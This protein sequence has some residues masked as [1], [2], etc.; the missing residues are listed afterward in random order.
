GTAV[1]KNFVSIAGPQGGN[2]FDALTTPDSPTQ[3]Y[4]RFD[5]IPFTTATNP[6]I[7]Q[8]KVFYH[9]YAGK[10]FPAYYQVYLR[11][12]GGSFYQDASFR[13]I[14][15]QGFI[16]AGDYF[17]ETRDLTAPSGYQ[18]MCIIVN[19]QEECGFKQVSTSF[20]VNYI[21]EQYVASQAT[22]TDITSEAACISG[23]PSVYSLLSPNLQAGLGEIT[24]PA[25][26]N[27]GITR[28]CATN[29]PGLGTD[30]FVNPE[31]MRWQRVG[32]C[33]NTKIQCWLDTDSVRD[34]I[35]NTNIQNEI[36]DD[37]TG[38]Y[39]E[40]LQREGGFLSDKQFE[41]L[42]EEINKEKRNL[43]KINKIN[44]N[45]D[46]IFFEHEKGYLI[47]LRADAYKALALTSY[48][49]REPPE[50]TTPPSTGDEAGL[51]SGFLKFPIFLFEDGVNDV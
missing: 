17:T 23:T 2:L 14:V 10:D 49:S 26:Y 8:Y 43:E 29:N 37:V 33:G 18:E 24:N 38:N 50:A 19:G 31:D 15:A 48:Y 22:Q 36:I 44:E 1:C 16:K 25:I 39:L 46:K 47:L 34:T 5:E 6:P 7:S 45:M 32:H 35:R 40:Q 27:R 9:I 28:I 42:V 30:G 21:T 4:G 13:R 11:G 20:G 41:E 3:F 12:T 51:I